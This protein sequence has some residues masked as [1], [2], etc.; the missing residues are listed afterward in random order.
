MLHRYLGITTQSI[1]MKY[2]H[3]QVPLSQLANLRHYSDIKLFQRDQG[4]K[5]VTLLTMG[6]VTNVS[7]N[8]LHLQ[9]SDW[10]VESRL[11]IQQFPYWTYVWKAR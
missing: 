11:R 4:L 8:N 10:S 6:F 5:L 1:T 9:P 2:P 7:C 3:L